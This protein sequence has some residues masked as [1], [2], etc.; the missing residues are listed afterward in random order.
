MKNLERTIIS[1][2]LS[3]TNKGTGPNGRKYTNGEIAFCTALG[4]A[5]IGTTFYLYRKWKS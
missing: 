5:I 3:G 1:V 4:A 2:I